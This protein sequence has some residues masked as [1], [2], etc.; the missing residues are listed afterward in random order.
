MTLAVNLANHANFINSSGELSASTGLTGAVPIANGGTNATTAAT[1]QVNLGIQTASTG[2]NVLAKGTQAQ[3]DAT[4]QAGYI[5]FNT[6]LGTFEGYNGTE[7]GA[8]GG[9]ATG[10]GGDAVFYLNEQNVTA[11]YTIPVGFNAGSVGPIGIAD[12]VN[13][14]VSTGSTWVIS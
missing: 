9:G 8:I 1:A 10:N 13:V 6:D 3:R 12:G 11:N 14:T 2:S 7:W 4:P 5:R